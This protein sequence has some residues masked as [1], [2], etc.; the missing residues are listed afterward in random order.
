MRLVANWKDI[1]KKSHSMWAGYLGLIVLTVPEFLFALL[2]YQV[3][4]PLIIGWVGVALL[5]YGVF[6]R[7]KAQGIDHD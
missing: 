2:G 1:M 7:L 4:N 5:L 6:G 3:V